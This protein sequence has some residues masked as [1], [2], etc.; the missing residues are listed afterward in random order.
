M[1]KIREEDVK[2]A[3]KNEFKELEE[4]H[5][6]I[7]ALYDE[8]MNAK[9]LIQSIVLKSPQLGNV[10]EGGF[11]RDLTEIM[12][13]HERLTRQREIEI[14]EEL[15]SLTEEEETVNRIKVCFEELRGKEYSYL[16]E[17]YV[18]CNPYKAVERESG[19]SHRTFEKIRQSGIRKII[20][21][22]ESSYCNQ[23]IIRR[24]QRG[25]QKK[26]RI[27]KEDPGYQ[28]LELKL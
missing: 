6:R 7:L 25:G 1:L 9:S 8:L 3:L 13:K 26:G 24:N 21:L 22:Y 27:K 23:D 14:R 15:R 2:R 4:I 17:L 18:K 16:Y 28:Q 12:L 20:Q 11:Q 5:N 19:V 10:G